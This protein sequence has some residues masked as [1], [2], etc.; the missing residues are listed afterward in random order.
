M[1]DS[2]MDQRTTAGGVSGSSSAIHFFS[3]SLPLIMRSRGTGDARTRITEHQNSHP[4]Q[5]RIV[6]RLGRLGR[7][8]GCAAGRCHST[9]ACCWKC[10]GPP[11]SRTLG[12]RPWDAAGGGSLHAPSPC[13]TA[14]PTGPATLLE[15]PACFRK[16]YLVVRIRACQLHHQRKTS[17]PPKAH[18][19]SMLPVFL[20]EATRM[21]QRRVPPQNRRMGGYVTVGAAYFPGGG[22]RG[23]ILKNKREI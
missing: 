10:L 13:C 2:G 9:S 11:A 15:S 21:V 19:A 17:T 8:S 5:P 3:A 23:W 20:C 18:A 22:R 16:L 6:G 14:Q 4:N 1:D 7:L 12:R